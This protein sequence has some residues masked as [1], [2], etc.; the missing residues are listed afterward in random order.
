M[1]KILRVGVQFCIIFTFSLCNAYKI[2]FVR[3]YFENKKKK[4]KIVK[5][6]SM[7]NGSIIIN[8]SSQKRKF[9]V[10]VDF[11]LDDRK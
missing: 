8:P 4:M 9:L 11:M 5:K 10:A 7:Q 3:H 6:K 1:C 2:I